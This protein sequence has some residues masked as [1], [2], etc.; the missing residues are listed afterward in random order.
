MNEIKTLALPPRL[1]LQEFQELQRI[2]NTAA[3]LSFDESALPL[4]QRRLAARLPLHEL[5]SYRDYA[6]LLQFGTQAE[7]ELNAALD[8]LQPGRWG[9]RSWAWPLLARRS[10]STIPAAP[11]VASPRS[12]STLRP[13]SCWPASRCACP[14]LRAAA[15]GGVT[16]DLGA[17]LVQLNSMPAAMSAAPASATLLAK[18]NRREWLMMNSRVIRSSRV[19]AILLRFVGQS[20][21]FIRRFAIA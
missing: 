4:F 12:C 1:S 6:R 5:T 9:W 13:G 21:S 3:G 18:G 7:A 2:F 17:L 16:R 19:A 14:A 10:I 8:S 11:A 15:F 20:N